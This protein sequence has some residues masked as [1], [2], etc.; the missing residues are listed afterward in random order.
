MIDGSTDHGVM[1]L[2]S[3][4]KNQSVYLGVEEFKAETGKV[5]SCVLFSYGKIF[6]Q[7]QITHALNS[8]NFFNTV[9]YVQVSL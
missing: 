2:R 5:F 7:S 3:Q 6:H 4:L 9:Y 8:K 1:L